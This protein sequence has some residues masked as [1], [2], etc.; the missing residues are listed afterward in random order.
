MKNLQSGSPKNAVLD[1]EGA[2]CASCVYTIEH[3]GRKVQGVRDIHVDSGKGE[4]RVYYEGNP[5]TLEKIVEI[6][7]SL[8]Y[9]AHI[10]WDSIS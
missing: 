2:N 4:I 10:R 5:G 9:N 7:R 6:V 8:G 3:L 1:V